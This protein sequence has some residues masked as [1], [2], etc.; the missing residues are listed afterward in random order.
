MFSEIDVEEA[1]FLGSDFPLNDFPANADAAELGG[2]DPSFVV[3]TQLGVE[4]RLPI[5]HNY[6]QASRGKEGHEDEKDVLR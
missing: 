4:N 2:Q 1:H 5:P 6:G 3:R